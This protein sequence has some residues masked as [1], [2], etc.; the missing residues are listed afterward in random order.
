MKVYEAHANLALTTEEYTIL[1][2]RHLCYSM[3]L[4]NLPQNSRYYWTIRY[5][6]V[7]Y[8]FLIH[9]SKIQ[10]AH[11]IAEQIHEIARMMKFSF[12]EKMVAGLK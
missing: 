3:Q 2:A 8:D 4:G 12:F 5:F 6:I 9:E 11:A 10:E 7:R 1:K